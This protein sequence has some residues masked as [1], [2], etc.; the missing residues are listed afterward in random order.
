MYSEVEAAR[1]LGIKP[2]SLRTE[3]TNGRIAHKSVAGK[4]MYR[5]SDLVAWQR[6]GEPC[7][8]DGPLKARNSSGSKR[9]GGN[10]RSGTFAGA[11]V[12][13]AASV[14]QAQAIAEELIRSSRAGSSSA[15]EASTSHGKPA[16]VIPLRPE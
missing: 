9:E 12:A 8:A 15:A 10:N 3:R 2:R 16:P 6:E 13:E 14:Q 11:K 1:R 4:I 5:H 7:R